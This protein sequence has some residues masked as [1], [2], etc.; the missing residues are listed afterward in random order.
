MTAGTAGTTATGATTGPARTAQDRALEEA[1]Q[2]VGELAG[3][4]WEVRRA[5]RPVLVRG[6][7]RQHRLLCAGCRQPSPCPTLQAAGGA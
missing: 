3:R 5:H 6:L 4:L 7:L 2:R 1:V